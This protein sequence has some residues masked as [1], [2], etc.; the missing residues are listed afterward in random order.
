[1]SPLVP[2][3][4]VAAAVPVHCCRHRARAELRDVALLTWRAQL[5]SLVMVITH[6][7]FSHP[8]CYSGGMSAHETSVCQAKTLVASVDLPTLST[9][10]RRFYMSANSHNEQ[11]ALPRSRGFYK[12]AASGN[13]LLYAVWRVA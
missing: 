3:G 13:L 2:K 12:A 11:I 7:H 10:K 9:P 4:V 1:M 8:C 5:E 6:M